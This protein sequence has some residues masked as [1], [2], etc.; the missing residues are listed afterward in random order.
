MAQTVQNL[1]FEP[2]LVL[3]SIDLLRTRGL[4]S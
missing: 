2:L 3:E 1:P 4:R